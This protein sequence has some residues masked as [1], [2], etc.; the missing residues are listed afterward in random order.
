M[1]VAERT[2]RPS[3]PQGRSNAWLGMLAIVQ[4]AILVFVL[5][6]VARPPSTKTGPLLG[7]GVQTS[8]ITAFT[9]TGSDGSKVSLE[10]DG[11]Q[12]VL[13]NQG[14]YPARSEERRVGKE[15]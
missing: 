11:T 4:A 12:W 13:P 10:R 3:R 15:C 7:N 1:S 2:V 5:L 6:T 14:G 9:V 8:D